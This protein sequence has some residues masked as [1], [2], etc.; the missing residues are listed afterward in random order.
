MMAARSVDVAIMRL[1]REG[2]A[3]PLRTADDGTTAIIL[4]AGLGKRA[5]ADIG[6]YTWDETRAI[7]A[8]ALGLELGIDVN[9]RNADG[10]TALHAAAYHAANTLMTFLIEKK[11]DVNARNFQ[12]QTPLLIAQGHL[13]CC[14]TFVRHAET[15]ELLRRSG[16]DENAGKRL[17]FGLVSYVEDKF[18]AK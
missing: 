14:T 5:N 8:V 6:Y 1:L 17:N 12:E 10:E 18:K 4:A 2:G 7:E 11:A 16:A 13:V 15:A 9:A 3:D